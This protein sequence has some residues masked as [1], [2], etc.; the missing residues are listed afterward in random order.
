MPTPSWSNPY[1]D[2]HIA[3]AM[4]PDVLSF[5]DI[6]QVVSAIMRMRENQARD[7]QRSSLPEPSK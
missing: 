4:A 2:P 7:N 5:P 3:A 6:G 1:N